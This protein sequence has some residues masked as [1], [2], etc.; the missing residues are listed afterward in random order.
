MR[1]HFISISVSLVLLCCPAIVIATH[2]YGGELLY[3]HDQGDAYIV[4]LTLYGDCSGENYD[5]LTNAFPGIDIYKDN[6]YY[7][8]LRLTENINLREEV[9]AVCPEDVNNTSCVNPEGKL[10]GVTKYVFSGT[11]FLPPA[12][13]WRIAFAAKM[14]N[15]SWAGR[16]T[17]I[18]N[19]TIGNNG[20]G[21][22]IY[23]EAFL[24]NEDGPNSSPQYSSI[25]TPYYCINRAQQYNQGAID[26]D[27]DSLDF[28]LIPALINNTVTTS[29]IP[30]A[31]GARPLTTAQGLFSFN[32]L[33]GQMS[34]TPS[35]LQHSV[36]V[37]KVEEYKNGKLV[38]S[39]MREMTFI[40]LDN[41]Q[42]NPPLGI[43]D[44]NTI[45]G[46]ATRDNVIN[47]CAGTP[48]VVFDIPAYDSDSDNIE[49]TVNNIPTGAKATVSK[50]S[51]GEPYVHFTWD[52]Q[53]V[54]T[55]IYNM[56]ITYKDDACPLF[57]SQTIAY[58]LQIVNE[59]E[60]EEEILKLTNCFD[61]QQMQFSI[62]NGIIPRKVTITHSN[63]TVVGSY[64]DTTGVVI[65]SFKVGKYKLLAESD[66]LLCKKE[67][68]FTVEHGGTYPY[69]PYN[70]D[71]VHCLY[72][73]PQEILVRP[74]EDAEVKWYNS[75][76][77]ILDGKPKYTTV[78]PANFKWYVSQVV[79]VCE[80]VL[81][82]VSVSVHDFPDIKIVDVPQQ[83][84]AG[85]AVYLQAEGGVKYDWWPEKAIDYHDDSA[86]V[87]VRKPSTYS[88]TG[89]DAYGCPNTDT[90]IF[91]EVEQCCTI[92]Y[93]DAFTPNNDGLNDSWHPLTYG[94]ADYF[95]LYV[96]D[97]WGKKVFETLNPRDRWDG[98]YNGKKCEIGTYHYYLRARCVTGHVEDKAGTVTLIR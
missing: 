78:K 64:V 72:D 86:Y 68:E 33:S 40:V 36:V 79:D 70:E 41:C 85:D 65:D 1:S 90:V 13:D 50:N 93:P 82:E 28:S 96:Y 34:F 69:P 2:I 20:G 53:D 54:P 37:N 27:N 80:S 48:D 57:S 47:I 43:I 59:I 77:Q 76:G 71:I 58:T 91:S 10:P 51:K 49:I 81:D 97:R 42:N 24:N 26:P 5:K 55:G 8:S 60:I 35:M 22:L 31:N 44:S 11:V 74:V 14:N 87:Y 39:S 38:G 98:S 15:A 83:I 7:D 25:P 9:S 94:N 52:T 12:A 30:P 4:T 21:D 17:A 19:I 84:C 3:T 46:G 67:Y 16:S 18:T 89:Y 45:G 32:S 6:A 75:E 56:Y 73:E 62:K 95:V 92:S 29:Y 61:M 23:L 88:V 66:V 63:G